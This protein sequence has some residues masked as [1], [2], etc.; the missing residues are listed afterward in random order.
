MSSRNKKSEIIFTPVS[1][2]FSALSRVSPARPGF[3]RAFFQPA[4]ATG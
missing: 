4:F 2:G 3:A 1:L